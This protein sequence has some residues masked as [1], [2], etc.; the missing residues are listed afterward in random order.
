MWD[1]QK[2]K[3]LVETY[4]NDGEIFESKIQSK[5]GI[6][7]KIAEK[8]FVEADTVKSWT[9]PSSTGPGTDEMIVKLENLLN[10]SEGSLGRRENSKEMKY[11]NTYV[12]V[13]E[14]SK[15]AIHDCYILMK[16]YLHDDEVE[17]EDCFSK[18]YA[19]VERNK[20]AIPSHIY[21]QI[22]ECIDTI[23]API[24]YE[25]EK[26]F[27]KCYDKELGEFDENGTFVFKDEEAAKKT[28]IQFMLTLI[29]IE[30]KLDSFAM[31][32]LYPVM[33]A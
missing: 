27:S 12:K 5:E 2:F 33:M 28:C 32:K 26:T 10:V 3:G 14:Y 30:E 23:L 16:E 1:V 7:K 8:M 9:R 6:Y 13:S 11:E 15:K 4:K 21:S 24:I 29:D 31:E 22:T 18:M 25:Q 19:D 17:S 20:I